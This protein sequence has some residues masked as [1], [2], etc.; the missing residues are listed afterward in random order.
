MDYAFIDKFY[1]I[2]ERFRKLLSHQTLRHSMTK[3]EFFTMQMIRSLEIQGEK[4]NTARLSEELTVSKSAI[5]QMVNSLENK[6][7]VIRKLEAE[8][9]RQPS[10]HLTD[11]GR[12]ILTQEEITIYGNLCKVLENFGEE[13]C[14]LLLDMLEDFAVLYEKAKHT[15]KEKDI[16][17][18]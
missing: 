7:F 18:S 17:K 13:R 14:T 5:S 10:I 12:H 16:S 11:R 15:A 8:D 9:R 1:A 4:V 3:P 6:S 2:A